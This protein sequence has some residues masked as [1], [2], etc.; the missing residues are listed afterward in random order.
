MDWLHQD[1][2]ALQVSAYHHVTLGLSLRRHCDVWNQM[3]AYAGQLTY[4][5]REALRGLQ[6]DHC[7]PEDASLVE[8]FVT[9]QLG[10]TLRKYER[11]L[12][13]VQSDNVYHGWKDSLTLAFDDCIEIIC[14]S[15]RYE[16]CSDTHKVDSTVWCID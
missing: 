1:A 10:D 8:R 13:L 7:A 14:R 16:H 12:H 9:L 4:D 6:Q 11:L 2:D 15:V 3:K 5:H